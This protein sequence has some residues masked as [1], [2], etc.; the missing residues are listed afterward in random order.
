[1]SSTK[2][3]LWFDLAKAFDTVTR[4]MLWEVLGKMG[5]PPWY[6]AVLRWLPDGANSRVVHMG[7]KSEPFP[8]DA[9]VSQCCVL[10]P[11]LFNLFLASVT[12]VEARDVRAEDCVTLSYR[13]DGSLFNLGRLRARTLT[14]S[15]NILDLQYA[16]DAA[17]VESTGEGLQRS[18][19]GMA[20]AYKRAGLRINAE[21]TE[22]LTQ[23]QNPTITRKLLV[24]DREF[25]KRCKQL[26]IFGLSA[27]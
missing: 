27:V 16:N 12:R 11:V 4:P 20:R 1:M 22:V 25:K 19:N 17:I 8:V 7:E 26:Q 23:L 14:Q 21:K 13:L 18:L 24:D 10:A 9:G 15:V 2:I 3:Y 5:C 6:L